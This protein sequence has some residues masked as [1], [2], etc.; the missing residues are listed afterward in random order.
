M[1]RE[2]F[3]ALFESCRKSCLPADQ[4]QMAARLAAYSD[5]KDNINPVGLAIFAYM[6]SIRYTDAML[7]QVLSKALNVPE[8]D[9]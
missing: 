7:Y 4:N 3:N 2:E 6:E 1:T 5:G 9:D 8:K